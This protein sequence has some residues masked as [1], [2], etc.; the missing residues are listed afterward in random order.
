[1]K[2]NIGDKV[3]F[4]DQVGGG[5][6][7]KII[8]P[9]IVA[10]LTEDDFEI[11]FSIN[12]LIK[13]EPPKTPGEKVFLATNPNDIANKHKDI[14]ASDTY[15]NLSQE[16]EE[17]NDITP[18]NRGF[19]SK[20][21][22]KEGIYIG[23][24][25]HDQQWM[26]KGG[27]NIYIINYTNYT[28]LYNF[29]TKGA[30][31]FY[32][33]DFA[34]IPPYSKKLVSSI[35]REEIEIWNEGIFQAMFHEEECQNILMP[36]STQYKIKANKF[37]QTE[38]YV[39]PVFMR[40]KVI[41]QSLVNIVQ[42][43]TANIIGH[44]SLVEDKVSKEGSNKNIVVKKSFL[45][46]YMI[47]KSTAEVD[48]HI[49]SL[50]EDSSSMEA[51]NILKLQIAHF[52]KCLDEGMTQKVQKMI[53]IHGVGEGTLKADIQKILGTYEGLHFFDAR[54]S[55]YGKGAIEVYIG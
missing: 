50:V 41:L 36:I 24:E 25:P 43:K 52:E 10:V 7:T 55:K 31:C 28:I 20:T 1:M 16:S 39:F 2:F 35:D 30:Q 42:H 9:T 26:L 14:E 48:L 23:F 32:G 27:F 15:T 49:E 54:M 17:D 37:L 19:V 45:Q 8:S 3:K 22:E 18:L 29:S 51:T 21:P 53:F 12:D 33:V 44:Q 5:I 46:A 47:D 40:N 6:I 38:S 11:P 13:L 4:T 34:S